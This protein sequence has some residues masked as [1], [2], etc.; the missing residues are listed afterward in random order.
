MADQSPPKTRRA[1]ALL[2][3]I[4]L[5]ACNGVHLRSPIAP[6]SGP[7]EAFVRTSSDARATRVIELG[8]GTT[9]AAAFSA[10]S[11]LLTQRFSIDVSDQHTGF[12]MT[13]WQASFSRAG[14][15][16]LHYRTRIIIRF[17]GDDW[18]QVSVRAD[19]NW[20]R[21]EEWDVGYDSKL[22][23][24]VITDLKSRIGKTP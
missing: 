22:L 13:P 3:V 6:A 20:Q 1:I 12:L 24:D 17:L 10:A 8:D 15:P 18:K 9:K 4:A 14:A 19:A 7:P 2:A 11:E 21:G 16:D 5:S 23:D